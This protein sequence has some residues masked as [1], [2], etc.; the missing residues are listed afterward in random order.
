MMNPKGTE[1]P[2]YVTDEDSIQAVVFNMVTILERFE[3][4]DVLN[5]AMTLY[6]A[7][8]REIRFK[9][10]DSSILKKNEYPDDYL[11]ISYEIGDITNVFLNRL[12]DLKRTG[13]L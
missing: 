3:P 7:R 9:T 2:Y 1:G 10:T 4:V 6:D 12:A 11:G 5:G 8:G 13:S